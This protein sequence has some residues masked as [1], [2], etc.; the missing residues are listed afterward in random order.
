MPWRS[1]HLQDVVVLLAAS[2]A[3]QSRSPSQY[4]ELWIAGNKFKRDCG[5][6]FPRP[7][8]ELSLHP[9]LKHGLLHQIAQMIPDLAGVNP[10]GAWYLEFVQT[11]GNILHGI[12]K[13]DGS[14]CVDQDGDFTH[15]FV[16]HQ[17]VIE[18]VWFADLQAFVAGT[19]EFD[20]KSVAGIVKGHFRHDLCQVVIQLQLHA[21]FLL[22]V[23]LCVTE[24]FVKEF[25]ECLIVISY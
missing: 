23:Y 17:S 8:H 18:L 10:F 20:F 25:F 9:Q 7:L 11:G 24:C 21:D 5:P 2:A 14:G 16:V 1:W 12:T 22:N 19:L 15:P 4:L 6:S 3:A 13:P